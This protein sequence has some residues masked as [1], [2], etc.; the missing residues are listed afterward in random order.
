MCPSSLVLVRLLLIS[1]IDS[2]TSIQKALFPS[3]RDLDSHFPDCPHFPFSPRYE[4]R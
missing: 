2:Y 3:S 1:H 4:P